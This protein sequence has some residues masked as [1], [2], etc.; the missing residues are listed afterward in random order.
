MIYCSVSLP[1]V[2]VAKGSGQSVIAV[3]SIAVERRSLA[4]YDQLTGSGA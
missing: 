2:K 1:K 4:L 3:P